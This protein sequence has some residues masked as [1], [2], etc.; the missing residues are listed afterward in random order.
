MAAHSHRIHSSFTYY[1]SL[2]RLADRNISNSILFLR[3]SRGIDVHGIISICCALLILFFVYF[4]FPRVDRTQDGSFYIYSTNRKKW[5]AFLKS[6]IIAKNYNPAEREKQQRQYYYKWLYIYAIIRNRNCCRCSVRTDWQPQVI[7]FVLICETI[8]APF[9]FY[10]TKQ[11]ILGYN[12]ERKRIN[13]IIFCCL[14][15]RLTLY[16]ICPRIQVPCFP[17]AIHVSF[18]TSHHPERQYS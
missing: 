10:Y 14:I 18:S 11:K 13:W 6:R 8:S 4:F 15:L 2:L 17:T 9:F 3:F 5:A 1:K 12:D 7:R 16:Y